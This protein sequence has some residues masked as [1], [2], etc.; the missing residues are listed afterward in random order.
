M[1]AIVLIDKNWGIGIGGE[2]MKFLKQ[3]LRNFNKLTTGNT[4]VM[5]Y[6]T[7]ISLPHGPLKNKRNIVFYDKDEQID[8]VEVVNSLQQFLDMRSS[9]GEIFVCGGASIY[10]MLLPYCKYAYVTKLDSEYEV[11]TY[12]PNLDELEDWECV[13]EEYGKFGENTCYRIYENKNVAL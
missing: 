13:Q 9:L 6:T 12:F 10:K 7:F 3:D 5:G 4:V 11:D 1:N 2:Q 8:G